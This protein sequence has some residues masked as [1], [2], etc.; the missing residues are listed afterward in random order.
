MT[1]RG[2]DFHRK[3]LL[4]DQL[5][6][7]K[8]VATGSRCDQSVLDGQSVLRHLEIVCT[9]L[10]ERLTRSGRGPPNLHAAVLYRQAGIGRSLVGCQQGIALDHC[11]AIERY[12]QLFGGDLSDR[13]DGAGPQLNLS[14]IDRD[15][16]RRVDRD[17][18][19]DF[20]G[21]DGLVGRARRFGVNRL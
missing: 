12:G 21:G 9:P 7:R 20:V 3:L 4:A 15:L 18:A 8:L 19:G 16:A 2:I 10:Q 11:Y 1:G 14:R 17:E 5:R 6:I 13:R